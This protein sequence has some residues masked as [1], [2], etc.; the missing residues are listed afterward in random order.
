MHEIDSLSG[1]SVAIKEYSQ[2][3]P[4]FAGFALIA[5]GLWTL[6]A[7]LKLGVPYFQTFP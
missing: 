2:Q 6:A 1:G 7:A 3:Q 4:R 5:A